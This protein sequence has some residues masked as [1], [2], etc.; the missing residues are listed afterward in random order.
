[1]AGIDPRNRAARV[2]PVLAV[3]ALFPSAA[4]A[5]VGPGAGLAFVGSV[6]AVVLAVVI[7][8]VA[9]VLFPLRLLRKALKQ[10]GAQSPEDLAPLPDSAESAKPDKL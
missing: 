9:L 4:Y 3:G 6:V 2:L 10:R 8:L 1:M 5:Y 7:A